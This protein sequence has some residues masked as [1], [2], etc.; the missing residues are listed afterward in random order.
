MRRSG[1]S[2]LFE[3][4]CNDLINSG[5]T[6]EQVQLYN[7]ELPDNFLNKTWETIYFEIKSKL[8]A[9]KNNYV[10]LDKIQNIERSFGLSLFK[11][12]PS[13]ILMPLKY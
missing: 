4:F 3:L 2:T 12:N 6:T 11:S 1:K 13:S 5:I 7:F 8:K 10:F 9:D